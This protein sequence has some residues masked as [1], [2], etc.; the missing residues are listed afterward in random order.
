MFKIM[1]KLKGCETEEIDEFETKKEADLMLI[2]YI[3]AFGGARNG[4]KLWIKK[5]R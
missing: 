4:W 5:V 2:E 1:G 3:M